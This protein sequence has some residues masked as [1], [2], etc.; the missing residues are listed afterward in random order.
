MAVVL[1]G[2]LVQLLVAKMQRDLFRLS[3]VLT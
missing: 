1:F 2:E 3:F